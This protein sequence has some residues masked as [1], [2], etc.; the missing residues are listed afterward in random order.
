[1]AGLATTVMGG[2][3]GER[4]THWVIY[5]DG[6]TTEVE[7]DHFSF[8][9]SSLKLTRWTIV[10]MRPKEVVVSRLPLRGARPVRGVM[11]DEPL[12]ATG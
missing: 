8:E 4:M 9:T 10:F 2:G 3:H 12:P 7:A 1:L 6:S 11:C 5:E